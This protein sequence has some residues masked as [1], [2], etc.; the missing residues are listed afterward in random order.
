MA[1]AKNKGM[2]STAE[3]R[4]YLLKQ[5]GGKVA[6]VRG[7]LRWCEAY[8]SGS[9]QVWCLTISGRVRL[10]EELEPAGGGKGSRLSRG[11]GYILGL[12]SSLARQLVAEGQVNPLMQL[13]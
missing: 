6:E 4:D 13:I 9:K 11:Q 7:G 2:S 8:L 5:A 1:T 12:Y 10:A 3:V